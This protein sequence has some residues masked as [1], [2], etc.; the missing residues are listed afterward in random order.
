MTFYPPLVDLT[1][2]PLW[3][4]LV[5]RKRSYLFHPLLLLDLSSNNGDAIFTRRLPAAGPLKPLKK[6]EKERERENERNPVVCGETRRRGAMV[7]QQL[8]KRG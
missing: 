4:V 3:L 8:E 1:D 6:R 2:Q 7:V 5:P